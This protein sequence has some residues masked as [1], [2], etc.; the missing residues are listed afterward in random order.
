MLSSFDPT[1]IPRTSNTA[2][3]AESSLYPYYGVISLATAFLCYAKDL[4]H[5][6]TSIILVKGSLE[7]N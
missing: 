7:V 3:L 6:S 1:A 2:L 5:F 4:A